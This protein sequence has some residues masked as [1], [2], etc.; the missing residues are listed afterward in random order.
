M[1]WVAG[2]ALIHTTAAAAVDTHVGKTFVF[3]GLH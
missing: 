3:A 2:S 1:G